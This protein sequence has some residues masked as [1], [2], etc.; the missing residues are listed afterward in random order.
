MA[1]FT[2]KKLAHYHW[3]CEASRPPQ[4]SEKNFLKIWNK[5]EDWQEIIYL[6]S[7][8]GILPTIYE[9]LKN[10]NYLSKLPTD[11]AEALE[12]FNELNYLFNARLRAQIESTTIILNMHGVTPV[13]LKG[14]SQLLLPDWS[15]SP[16]TMLDLDL[17]VPNQ[18][19]HSISLEA[20]Y[21][22]GYYIQ[23]E[24]VDSDH[25]NSQHFAPIIKV[26]QPARL[27]IHKHVVSPHCSELLPDR[28]AF[29]GVEWLAK[30]G[31][32]YG[33]LSKDLQIMQSFLQCTE[34]A[35]DSMNPR[36]TP[37]IMK[38]I[39][40]LGRFSSP[41]QLNDWCLSN[42]I[43]GQSPWVKKS[44]QLSAL[45][46]DFFAITTVIPPNTRYYLGVKLALTIPKT[47]AVINIVTRGFQ[48][49]WQGELGKIQDWPSKLWRQF[50]NL[51][52]I[53]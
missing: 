51:R 53:R 49:L 47:E 25:S 5:D 43:I 30:D 35:S 8:H 6:A 33:V 2:R 37:R 45:L 29:Q 7:I 18:Q 14:A 26:G 19:D 28:L 40:F 16:R 36:N 15:L 50:L 12:G 13:W 4:F 17:W 32:K 42:Q 34:Q 46:K 38:I 52:N 1:Y 11:V 9:Q 10:K 41:E 3:L 23:P 21:K 44:G 39:D 22:E 24:S 31:L 27:E 20:L 48:L